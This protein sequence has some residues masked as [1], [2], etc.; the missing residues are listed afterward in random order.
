MVRG[1][2]ECHR[3]IEALSAG[4][5]RGN[6]IGHHERQA[7]HAAGHGDGHGKDLH[8]GGPDLSLPRVEGHQ[9]SP[10]PCRPTGFGCPGRARVRRIQHAEGAQV[11]P[12][13]RGFQPAVSQ[14]GLRRRQALRSEGIARELPD[15]AAGHPHLRLCLHHPANG[16][17]SL[18]RGRRLLSERKRSRL[19]G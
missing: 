5:H 15:R 8:D 16:D 11:R 3:S 10:F 9:E 1:K 19:R 18:R 17:Q 2:P 12:G 14:G 13:V 4:G 7:R 6:R